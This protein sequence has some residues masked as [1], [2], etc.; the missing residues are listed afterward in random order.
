MHPRTREIRL[1]NTA[2]RQGLELSR[3]RRRDQHAPDYDRWRIRDRW[4]AAR[5]VGV[6]QGVG[7][8]LVDA[9]TN[10]GGALRYAA[11]LTLDDVARILDSGLASTTMTEPQQYR[12]NWHSPPRVATPQ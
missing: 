2:K 12:G 6:V 8:T 4:N 10:R 9:P 7:F 3:S 5:V 11:W 1:R